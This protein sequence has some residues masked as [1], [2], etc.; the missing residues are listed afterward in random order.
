MSA[1]TEHVSIAPVGGMWE[2][3]NP[4]L[5]ELGKKGSG[6]LVEVPRG[7]K[8]DLAS[9]PWYGRAIFKTADATFAKASIL[10]DFL[11]ESGWSPITAGAEFANALIADGVARWRATI[12]GLAVLTVKST[13]A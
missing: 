6:L 9:I 8:T 12:M 11:L 7:F 4:L 3:E 5:W 1:Y 10:H 13:G 2:L